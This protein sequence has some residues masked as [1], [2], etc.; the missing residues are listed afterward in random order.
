MKER[1]REGERF[2][3]ERERFEGEKGRREERRRK[4]K[5][6]KEGE[7]RRRPP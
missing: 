2:G 5:E 3:R 7:R 4:K 6:K 1:A